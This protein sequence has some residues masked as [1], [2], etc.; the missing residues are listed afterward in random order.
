MQAKKR[1]LFSRR[2]RVFKIEPEHSTNTFSFLRSKTTDDVQLIF[3]ICYDMNFYCIEL[4]R[5]VSM[6]TDQ[7]FSSGISCLDVA[8]DSVSELT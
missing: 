8:P 4:K 1:A 5:A 6:T 3:G 2:M 7:L